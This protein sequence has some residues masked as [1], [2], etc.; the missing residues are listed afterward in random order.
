M[1]SQQILI[2]AVT[3]LLSA[4]GGGSGS[5]GAGSAAVAE[6]VR[7]QSPGGIWSNPYGDASLHLYVTERG[8]FRIRG[9]FLHDDKHWL[10]GGGGMVGVS[11]GNGVIG[12]FVAEALWEENNSF[13]ESRTLSCDLRGTVWERHSMVMT[14]ECSGRDVAWEERAEFV[15]WDFSYEYQPSS[16][17]AIAG[18]YAPPEAPQTNTLNINA[19]GVVFGVYHFGARCTINGQVTV[20]DARYNLYWMEWQFSN[21]THSVPGRSG[22]EFSGIAYIMSPAVVNRREGSISVLVSGMADSGFSFF[23]LSYE[24]V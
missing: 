8:D 5:G 17:D 14:I 10:I 3:L 7:N 4:C 18:N 23:S 2:G 13:V 21:C 20:V 24:P 19:D 22:A 16:L 6:P 15:Y 11:G 1:G 9:F 12:N